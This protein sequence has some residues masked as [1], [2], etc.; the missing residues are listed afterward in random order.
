MEHALGCCVRLVKVLLGGEAIADNKVGCGNCL[1]I[2]GVDVCASHNGFSF[3][4]SRGK[5]VKWQSELAR[6]L[7][8]KTLVPGQAAKLAGKLS[9]GCTHMFNKFGRAML[10]PLFDQQSRRD[11]KVGIEL[12]RAL[13]CW[14]SVLKLGLTE[15]REWSSVGLPDVHLF[16]D[17]S[18]CPAHLGAVLL[19]D[20]AI[21]WTH[22]VPCAELVNK[23]RKRA[24]NQI[25]GLELLSISLGL[26]TSEFW[27]K[28]RK[29]VVHSD[30]TGSEVCV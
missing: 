25:M 2:L 29:V 19:L 21:M 12:C 13:Q 11:G 15:R 23:F 27:L 24:H 26:C 22:M 7:A 5:V 6:A 20:G 17:A 4:P 10:R 14:Q 9:W 1:G 18:G 8:T 3:R 30:N 28:G 16:C